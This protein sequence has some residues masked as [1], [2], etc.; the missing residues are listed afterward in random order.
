MSEQRRARLVSPHLLDGSGTSALEAARAVV[1]LH[2]TDPATVYLSALARCPALTPAD[3]AAE[4]YD[5]AASSG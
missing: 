3:V 1:V 5:D 4:L 2:A